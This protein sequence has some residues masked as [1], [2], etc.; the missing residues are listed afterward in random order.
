M[1]LITSLKENKVFLGLLMLI[2]FAYLWLAWQPIES[3][4]A[5]FLVDDA[6]YYFKTAIN[7]TSGLGP[8]FDGEH[9]T[10]GYHPLWMGISAAVFYF[11]PGD[12][13]LPL[14]I[15]LTLSAILFFLTSVL[16]W[17]IISTFTND[18]LA[19]SLLVL[20]YAIN[21][22]NLSFYLSGL[23]TPLALFLFTVFFRIFLKILKGG[24]SPKN[25]ILLG[26]IGGLLVLSRLDYGVFLAAV[27]I[28]LGFRFGKLRWKQL[29]FFGLPAFLL[30]APWFLYNYFYFGS[31]VPASGLAYT[32]INHRLWFYKERSLT[33]IGL[34]SL[35]NFFGTVASNISTLGWPIYYSTR[36]M[37]K[38]FFWMAGTA[39]IPSAIIFYFY[40]KKK[41][42][43]GSFLK[44]LFSSKEWLALL[45]FFAGYF[46][47]VAG[48]GAIRWSGRSWYFATFP[49]FATI[50][51]ALVLS[52]ATLYSYRRKALVVLAVLLSVSYLG[53]FNKI[54]SE[55]INQLG[56]Y[57]VAI[58][59]KNNLPADARVAAFNSGIM[60]YF[61]D[62]FVMN[63]DGLINNS[64]YKAMKENKIWQLF[65]DNRI[66]Y[67]VDYEVV[68]TYRYK[69]FFGIDDPISRVTKIDTPELI[70]AR[71][72]GGT[73]VNVYKL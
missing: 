35:H 40:K 24:D 32:L 22:W 29:L 39:L 38:S 68:L 41:M 64:A 10:N 72:Y 44:E 56:M 28:F 17:K 58:W 31:F 30:A 37:L 4:L 6:F 51:I 15:I 11:F 71:A 62:R 3:L 9:A 52:R 18:K 43:L 66:D 1:N 16:I 46:L 63:S 23:E 2:F 48:H 65:Q 49:I 19:P 57:Q 14:H 25:L 61:S 73:F 60:G 70:G 55:N 33:Y 59:T 12:K 20:T 53:H 8:T 69:S 50:F 27:F 13:I 5:R 67:L 45:V 7:L 36:D 34:W 21:P 42:E 26:I 47:L 54:L